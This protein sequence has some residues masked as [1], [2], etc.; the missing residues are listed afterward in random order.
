MTRGLTEFPV[1]HHQ[2]D[3]NGNFHRFKFSFRE[4]TF[5]VIVVITNVT[6]IYLCMCSIAMDLLEN[7]FSY[8]PFK[9]GLY[10]HM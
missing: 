1:A 9:D 10:I 7:Y 5:D 8:S 4:I 6:I 3:C 2:V